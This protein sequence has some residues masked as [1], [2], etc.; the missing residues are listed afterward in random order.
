[1]KP[2]ALVFFVGLTVHTGC[3]SDSTPASPDAALGGSDAPASMDT[4][5]DARNCPAPLPNDWQGRWSPP[6]AHPGTCT[7]AQ[8][9]ELYYRCE[10]NSPSYDPAACRFYLDDAANVPCAQCM[11]SV[12]TDDKWRA[13]VLLDNG[14]PYANVG[15]CIALLDG[16]ATPTSCGAKYWAYL[17]CEDAVC[18]ECKGADYAGCYDVVGVT[19][20]L[21]QLD[22][23]ICR[24]RTKYAICTEYTQYRDYFFGIGAVFCSTGFSGVD[25]AGHESDSAPE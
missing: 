14:I 13:I 8:I 17:Q 25:D 3:G 2:R 7:D 18:G 21:R 1:M 23:A 9:Q 24:R 22:D 10:S 19:A 11:Y 15:G 16:D 20:C 12:E 6:E 4:A 5:G